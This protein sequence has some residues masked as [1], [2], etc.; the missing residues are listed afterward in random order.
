MRIETPMELAK[1]L[2][3]RADTMKRRA[4]MFRRK[5]KSAQP[6]IK[7]K[8]DH[9]TKLPKRTENDRE[10]IAKKI[11]RKDMLRTQYLKKARHLVEIADANTR[12][13]VIPEE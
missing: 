5:L 13:L 10:S 2:V 6:R 3:L 8:I 4:D 7:N 12:P 9:R 11:E 1:E